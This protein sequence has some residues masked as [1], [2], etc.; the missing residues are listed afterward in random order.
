VLRCDQ[1]HSPRYLLEK[2]GAIRDGRPALAMGDALTHAMAYGAQDAIRTVFNWVHA[3]RNAP[4]VTT[5][6]Q[7]E[8]Y[9]SHGPVEQKVEG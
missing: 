2:I 9:L 5:L 7:L 8:E 4:T 6:G 3:R 1:C